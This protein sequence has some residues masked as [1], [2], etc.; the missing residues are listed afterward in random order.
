MTPVARN[1]PSH[2]CTT[3]WLGSKCAGVD[4]ISAGEHATKQDVGLDLT[5]Y[6]M[7]RPKCSSHLSWI[8]SGESQLVQS[9]AAANLVARLCLIRLLPLRL[10]S[11]FDSGNPAAAVWLCTAVAVQWLRLLG[12]I[13]G[14]SSCL[15]AGLYEPSGF[16]ILDRLLGL[17]QFLASIEIRFAASYCRRHCIFVSSKSCG[18]HQRHVLDCLHCHGQSAHCSVSVASE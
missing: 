5:R 13:H 6:L 12:Q 4:A 2:C 11:Y 1:I 9:L 7:S 18:R 15:D 8:W 3:A 14:C 16:N 10:L 17:L